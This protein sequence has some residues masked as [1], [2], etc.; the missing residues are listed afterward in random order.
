MIG[1][2]RQHL[3]LGHHTG[4]G[5]AIQ[6]VSGQTVLMAGNVPPSSEGSRNGHYLYSQ[7]VTRAGY[8]PAIPP[9]PEAGRAG[10]SDRG[11]LFMNAYHDGATWVLPDLTQALKRYSPSNP[12]YGSR[13][14]VSSTDRPYVTHAWGGYY[15]MFDSLFSKTYPWLP[16]WSQTNWGMVGTSF[17]HLAGYIT[18]DL[19]FGIVSSKCLSHAIP[20]YSRHD[21]FII[22]EASSE[23]GANVTVHACVCRVDR[24]AC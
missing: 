20:Q 3:I 18:G 1:P 24:Q 23:Y 21:L 13:V 17:G 12:D 8:I 19:I 16:Y 10:I 5:L 6:G 2:N 7:L 4:N 15:E 14:I 22:V 9:D 11:F